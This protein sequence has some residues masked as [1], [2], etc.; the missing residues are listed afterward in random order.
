MPEAIE[1]ST[2]LR[3]SPRKRVT[4]NPKRKQRNFDLPEEDDRDP[5]IG[6]GNE[7]KSGQ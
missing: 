1:A 5:V 3:R 4:R 7:P 6:P 2:S